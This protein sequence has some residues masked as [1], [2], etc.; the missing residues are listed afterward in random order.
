M[1]TITRDFQFDAG[2]RV[3]NHE[4]KCAH[5]HGH[6]Y[7]AEVTVQAPSLDKLGRVIDFSCL[8]TDIGKW[9]DDNWDHNMLLHEG[10]PLAQVWE[11]MKQGDFNML[12]G[13]FAGKAPY[14]FK[15]MRNPTAENI[16]EELFWQIRSS[17]GYGPD[18][19]KLVQVV[20]VTIHETPN[21][22]ATYTFH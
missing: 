22:R 3:L 8:K 5:L 7:K 21:C 11:L 19:P 15:G 10:D 6:R 13:L 4:S 1:I 16:A 14:I 9:I 12:K 2:H 18:S 17:L 20:S